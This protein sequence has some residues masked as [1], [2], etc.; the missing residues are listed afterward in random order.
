MYPINKYLIVFVFFR[1]KNRRGLISLLDED[2][3]ACIGSLG[4]AHV[5]QGEVRD[6]SLGCCMRNTKKIGRVAPCTLRVEREHIQ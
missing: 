2:L 3:N 6:Q 1:N 5:T 4:L